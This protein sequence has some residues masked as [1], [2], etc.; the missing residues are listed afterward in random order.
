TVNLGS[1]PVRYRTRPVQGEPLA[2]QLRSVLDP[3]IKANDAQGAE[4]QL[5]TYTPQLSSEA[6]AEAGQRVAFVYYVLGLDMD[7]RRVADTWRQGASG[8]WASQAAWVSGLASWRLG[9]FNAASSAFQQVAQLAD[10]R[11]L[12]AGAFY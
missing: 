3:L 8:E 12:R 2:D 7:A 6:R 5:L 9:D 10:Q 1:A 11:E 4:A